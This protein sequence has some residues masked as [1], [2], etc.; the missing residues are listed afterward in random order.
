[1][2][3]VEVDEDCPD[4]GFA[5]DANGESCSV[6]F[7]NYNFKNKIEMSFNKA[8]IEVLFIK[9]IFS[10]RLHDVDTFLYILFPIK[11]LLSTMQAS[12]PFD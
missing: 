2:K 10:F 7:Q 11:Y 12:Q 9:M 1:M 5:F 6:S 4:F 8:F 3:K